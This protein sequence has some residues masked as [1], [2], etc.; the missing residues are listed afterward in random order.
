MAPSPT[1]ADPFAVPRRVVGVMAGFPRPWFFAGGWA[2]DVWLGRVT[3]THEDIEIVY[4]GVRPGEKLYEELSHTRE[5]VT[6]T[7][8]PKIMRFI[9][10]P[11]NY[12]YVRPFLDEL[13]S[14]IH[15]GGL[16]PDELKHLLV[17]TVAEYTPFHGASSCRLYRDVQNTQRIPTADPHSEVA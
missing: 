16:G 2:L 6:A 1:E 7:E 9:S 17:K 10:Q 12:S 14:A 5:N 3:R 8:H 15:E 13:E 4:T 11:Q